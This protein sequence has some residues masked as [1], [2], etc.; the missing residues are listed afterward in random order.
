[1]I[2]WKLYLNEWRE[3]GFYWFL[4]IAGTITVNLLIYLG[5]FSHDVFFMPLAFSILGYA[6]LCGDPIARERKNNTIYIKKSLPTPGYAHLLIKALWLMS[7]YVLYM[8]F[9][10]AVNLKIIKLTGF[11]LLLNSGNVLLDM[12][13]LLV[14]PF[15]GIVS[16][17]FSCLVSSYVPR[18]R[19][20][21]NFW[22]YILLAYITV[23]FVPLLSKLFEFLPDFLLPA[24]PGLYFN[25]AFLAAI[26][27]ISVLLLFVNG[28]LWDNEPFI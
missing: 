9:W 14:L 6:I 22:A 8:V 20:I 10:Y 27:A 16:V 5:L 4:M 1:M 7:S 19:C 2:L 18:L 17:Q 3:N 15:F 12:V 25:S 23:R 28:K 24:S 21:F 26:F 13:L 11:T